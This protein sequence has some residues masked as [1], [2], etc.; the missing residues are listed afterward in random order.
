MHLESNHDSEHFQQSRSSNA[1][2]PAPGF[3]RF[4][5]LYM[6]TRIC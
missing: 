4:I 2:N 3:F 5:I 1:S 6:H